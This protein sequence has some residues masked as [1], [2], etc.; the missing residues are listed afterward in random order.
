MATPRRQILASHGESVGDAHSTRYAALV[1]QAGSALVRGRK[2][3]RC[4]EKL[5]TSATKILLGVCCEPG[6]RRGSIPYALKPRRIADRR[7]ICGQDLPENVACTLSSWFANRDA[8]GYSA[9]FRTPRNLNECGLGSGARSE[10]PEAHR[11]VEDA[12]G[13][14][15]R[16]KEPVGV[17]RDVARG[18][19]AASNRR[20][21]ISLRVIGYGCPSLRPEQKQ[22]VSGLC[23]GIC[24]A[25]DRSGW[26]AHR[27]TAVTPK[28]LRAACWGFWDGACDQ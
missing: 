17:F 22:K 18:L 2:R 23:A 19:R 10:V 1:M 9:C 26:L 11:L 16:S 14:D 5:Q 25:G 6:P 20:W 8:K 13:H 27:A 15:A 21:L 24:A 4:K 3:C 28:S 7:V 12:C